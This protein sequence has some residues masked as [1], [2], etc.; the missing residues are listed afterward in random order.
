MLHKL[1][2]NDAKELTLRQH[3]K[4]FILAQ[5]FFLPASLSCNHIAVAYLECLCILLNT[6]YQYYLLCWHFFCLKI[7]VPT[8]TITCVSI[9]VD[10]VNA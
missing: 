3:P 4:L 5:L 10:Q 2:P 8:P 6:Q 9:L 7:V 1:N